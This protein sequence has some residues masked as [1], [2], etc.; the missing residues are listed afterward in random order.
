M[1]LTPG[2][3][4]TTATAGI[5]LY[6]GNLTTAGVGLHI[7]YKHPLEEY[8][9]EITQSSYLQA[10][11]KYWILGKVAKD[12]SPTAAKL[13]PG[14][15][16]PMIRRPLEHLPEAQRPIFVAAAEEIEEARTANWY[17]N[18]ERAREERMRQDESNSYPSVTPEVQ[19]VDT[20]QS[21][22]TSVEN[23]GCASTLQLMDRALVS[24]TVQSIRDARVGNPDLT[25]RQIYTM[26]AGRLQEGFSNTE[27]TRR[28]QLTDT[29]TVMGLLLG[30]K[31]S[32]DAAFPRAI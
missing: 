12:Y 7:D 16:D 26:F 24:D 9:D 11:S 18:F 4:R 19:V 28:D 15:Y 17:R 32:K 27:Q 2:I 5:G 6:T 10:V 22:I 29:V 21:I 31:V 13:F 20:L 23:D 8:P 25:D 30:G 3:L 14:E 1:L